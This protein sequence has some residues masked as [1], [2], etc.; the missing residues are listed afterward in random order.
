[1]ERFLRSAGTALLYL[2]GETRGR[3]VAL[4]AGGTR[5]VVVLAPD[6]SRQRVDV[7]AL[8]AALCAS[9][10]VP[11]QEQV[12]HLLQGAGLQGARAARARAALLS[13]SLGSRPLDGCWLL[14]PAPGSSFRALLRRAGLPR[15]LA[16][17]VAAHSAQY[18]LWILSWWMIGRGALQG[19]IEPGWLAAWALLLLTLVPF[20][21][22]V[23][24]WQGL[25][26]IG[27]GGLLK[28]RLL[29]G[30]LNLE[31]DEI[32]HQGAGQLLG[33]VIESEAVESL[34]LSGG[35]LGLVGAIEL[36]AAAIILAIGSG[37][38][39]HALLLAAWV[40]GTALVGAL[41][42]R[43]RRAWTEQRVRLT[44]D[45]VE[46]M[47]GHR[48]RLAQ[49]PRERWHAGE[50]EAVEQLLQRG[51]R[52]DRT[53]GWLLAVAPRGWLVLGLLGLA[54]GFIA[55]RISMTGLAIGLGGTLLAYRAVEKVAGS[56]WHLSG[57]V[58]AWN[59]VASMFRAASRHRPVGPPGSRPA[60]REGAAPDGDPLLEANNLIFRY[61]NRGEPVLRGC[62]LRL[63]SGDRVVLEGSSGGGKSTLAS[64]LAGLRDPESGLLLLDGLDRRTLGAAGWLRR[65]V[66]APQFHENHVLA[67]TFAFNLLMGRHWPPTQEDLDE[68]ETI[69]RELGLGE[70]LDRMPAGLL[71]LVGETGWQL[72]HGERSRLYIARAL[73]QGAD[74]VILDESFAALDPEN[75]RRC[76]RCV[77]DRAPSLLVIAHP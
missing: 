8:R 43:Q 67:E 69:C 1:M 26:A 2:P 52:M 58:V 76:M 63:R 68:A 45:L 66:A 5:G 75:L 71:Q 70:L 39:F 12:D 53:A 60:E 3:F 6:L 61:R 44:H 36:V 56:V 30:A 64:L 18:G 11:L 34:A 21:M 49:Q 59:S 77:R 24:W 25:L 10:E 19:R 22:L 37:G 32:R 42:G 14:R 29:A 15:R 72:S 13:R 33:R 31:A 48:T 38:A 51:R 50:D 20:R 54:P 40:G 27:T 65:V 73:L 7:D 35:F 41:Y 28:R 62:S 23:T 46:S 9:I 74:L 16:A 55:G 4:L 47:V 57:A 17:L